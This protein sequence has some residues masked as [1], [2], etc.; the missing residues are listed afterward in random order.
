MGSFLPIHVWSL[1]IPAV[2]DSI[3][4]HELFAVLNPEEQDRLRKAGSEEYQT[5]YLLSHALAR[6]KIADA[7]GCLPL[8]LPLVFHP[9]Q[10]PRFGEKVFGRD[11]YLSVTHTDDFVAVAFGA[12][13][14]G[15]DLEKVRRH[16]MIEEIVRGRGSKAEAEEI[17]SLSEQRD[18]QR[19]R[20]CQLWTLKEALYKA[21]SFESAAVMKKC[22]FKVDDK[23]HL[24]FISHGLCD[25][26][27]NEWQF[28]LFRP[29]PDRILALSYQSL[30]PV[31]IVWGD[32]T[33]EELISFP[34]M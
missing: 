32:V 7:L 5:Q 15:V 25:E 24:Q 8:D 12:S 23:D 11:W 4:Q 27:V 14:V 2:L 19:T 28:S 6:I 20:F 22:T 13:P 3:E 31:D 34:I 33:Q 10:K 1:P 18:R 26:E 30:S 9:H 21:G 16:E 29:K 17:E